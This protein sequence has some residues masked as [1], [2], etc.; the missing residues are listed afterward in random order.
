MGLLVPMMAC[1]RAFFLPRHRFALESVAL[2]QQLV[3]FKRKELARNS[4]V[5]IDYFGPQFAVAIQVGPR[6]SFSL[7]P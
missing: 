3:V 2:R 7:N 4:I 6:L 1:M 5:S